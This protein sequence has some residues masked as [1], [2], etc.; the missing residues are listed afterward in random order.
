MIN[1]KTQL[2]YVLLLRISSILGFS[3]LVWCSESHRVITTKR[4]WR[5]VAVIGLFIHLYIFYLVLV[6]GQDV[7]FWNKE[8]IFE[9]FPACGFFLIIICYIFIAYNHVFNSV[10]FVQFINAFLE[11]CTD[12]RGM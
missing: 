1:K 3:P 2:L 9:I 12:F 8:K 10:N 7:L 6:I 11:L 4:Q 5:L